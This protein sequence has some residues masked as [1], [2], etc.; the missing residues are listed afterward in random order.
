MTLQDKLNIIMRIRIYSREPSTINYNEAV[1]CPVEDCDDRG[2]YIDCY[3]ME[4]MVNC[5]VYIELQGR[6]K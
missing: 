5:P 6:W 2:K 1:K 4:R 3:S